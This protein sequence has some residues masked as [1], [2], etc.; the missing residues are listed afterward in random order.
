LIKEIFTYEPHNLSTNI[1]TVL[2]YLNRVLKRHAIVFLISDCNDTG[3]EKSL[4]LTSKK[5]DL[6]VLR[7][8][9]PAEET[10]PDVGLTR[11]RDPETGQTFVI[12]TSNRMLRAKWRDLRKKEETHFADLLKSAGIDCV[13]L[14]TDKPVMEPLAK[15]FQRRRKR[16]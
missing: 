2:R 1:D 9:D 7:I 8:S 3:F 10:L 12:N 6:T 14:V 15:L 5:H 16:L 4:R 11:L 13:E